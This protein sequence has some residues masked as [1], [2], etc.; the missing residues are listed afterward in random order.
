MKS[1]NQYIQWI[2]LNILLPVSQINSFSKESLWPVR[3]L[4]GNLEPGIL[5]S[6][7]DMKEKPCM[8]I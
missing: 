1:L 5:V 7:R 2:F 4:Q 3:L 8:M 6:G